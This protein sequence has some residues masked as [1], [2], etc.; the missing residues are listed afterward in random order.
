[1]ELVII[2]VIVLFVVSYTKMVDFQDL[3][4]NNEK[5]KSILKEKDYEFYAMAKYGGDVDINALFN[6]RIKNTGLML[7]VAMLFLLFNF[8]WI[9]LI[10]CCILVGAVYKSDY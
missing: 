3:F 5:V 6:K 9:N 2:S 4:T 10:I 8:S 1:M 7:I